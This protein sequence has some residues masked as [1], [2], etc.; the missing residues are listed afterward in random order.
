VRKKGEKKFR[1]RIELQIW[2]LASVSVFL[3]ER[4]RERERERGV[5]KK[6]EKKLTNFFRWNSLTEAPPVSNMAEVDL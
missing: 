1:F 4:E 3:R 2:L 6:G 5:R